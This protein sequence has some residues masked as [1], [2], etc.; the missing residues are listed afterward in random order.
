MYDL[1]IVKRAKL[2][3]D[4]MSLGINPMNGQYVRKGDSLSQKRI[5][6]CMGY[7]S[8]MLGD[9]IANDG[10]VRR[11]REPFA[12]TS[13]QR[14]KIALSDEPI[15]VN[16][17]AKRINA[18]IDS[19]FTLTVSGAKIASWVADCGYL[20]VVRGE[21]NKSKKVLNERSKEFG[22]TAVE[23]QNA[24]TGEVYTKLV[25]DKQAQKTILEHIDEIAQ[26]N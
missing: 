20:D 4:A 26:S 14:A 13:R 16:E 23:A 22:I 18:V 7:V 21:N 12:I 10:R 6:D 24:A 8:E 5:Q 1:K 11:A 17:I 3:V 25:Y 2:Y 15:G 19:D 9:L